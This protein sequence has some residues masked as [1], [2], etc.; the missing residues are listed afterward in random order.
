MLKNKKSEF[1]L[2]EVRFLLFIFPFSVL[3]FHHSIF[4]NNSGVR[5]IKYKRK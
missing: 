4:L 3:Q 1:F 2:Q 5:R